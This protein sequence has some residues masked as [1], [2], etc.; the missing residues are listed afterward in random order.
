MA[1]A[2]AGQSTLS[3]KLTLRSAVCG[4]FTSCFLRH[5][6]SPGHCTLR[7]PRHSAS[8]RRPSASAPDP[9]SVS[10]VYGGHRI[11][12]NRNLMRGL[13]LRSLLQP[14]SSREQ[15]VAGGSTPLASP[16]ARTGPGAPDACVGGAPT[17]RGRGGGQWA[18]AR[19]RA[20]VWMWTWEARG[21]RAGK[22]T[23]MGSDRPRDAYVGGA[24]ALSDQATVRPQT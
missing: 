20:W 22:G 5:S 16:C 13:D 7:L 10:L 4:L 3:M 14:P 8:R 12:A 24:W 15:T 6:E 2:S 1:T 23:D 17:P 21:I 19:A 9:S 18:W 11:P